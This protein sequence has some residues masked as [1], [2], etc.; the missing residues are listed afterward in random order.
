[1]LDRFWFFVNPSL[2]VLAKTCHDKNI[3]ELKDGNNH[4]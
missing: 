1:M 2:D 4:G 3:P